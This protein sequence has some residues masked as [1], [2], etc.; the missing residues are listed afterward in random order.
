MTTDTEYK[1]AESK[2]FLDQLKLNRG[3]LDKFNFYLSAFISAARSVHWVMN[4][5]YGKVPGWT[6]WQKMKERTAPEDVKD[7]LKRTKDMRNHAVKRGS[8]MAE[9]VTKI[10][11]PKPE[12]ERLNK[13][14]PGRIMIQGTMSNCRFIHMNAAGEMVMFQTVKLMKFGRVEPKFFPHKDVLEECQTY[15]DVL[16]TFVEE[17]TEKF[18]NQLTPKKN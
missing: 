4:T 3:K 8:V 9:V 1:L 15:Y 18:G 17:C 6:M 13:L 14:G 11:L 5:E 12:I 7:L 2:F 10:K 16:A